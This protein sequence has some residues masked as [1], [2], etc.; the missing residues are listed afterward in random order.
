MSKRRQRSTQIRKRIEKK[1]REESKAKRRAA[2]NA[3]AG[4][5]GEELLLSFR[6]PRERIAACHSALQDLEA[7]LSRESLRGW[8][9][10]DLQGE[11]GLSWFTSVLAEALEGSPQDPLTV[12]FLEPAKHPLLERLG[13]LELAASGLKVSWDEAGF[14]ELVR[15]VSQASE[16]AEEEPEEEEPAAEASSDETE[17]SGDET[18]TS[19]DETETSGDE[20]EPSEP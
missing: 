10:S 8:S 12:E 9:T 14:D 20:A 19:G 3:G 15:A 16:V 18:E 7:R 5:S 11:H 1:Q 17:A 13:A 6:L 2:K 4:G